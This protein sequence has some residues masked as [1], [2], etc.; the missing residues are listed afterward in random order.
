MSIRML[1]VVLL[2]LMVG[3]K[4][5]YYSDLKQ[6]VMEGCAETDKSLRSD[7]A[8]GLT[9]QQINYSITQSPDMGW[10]EWNDYLESCEELYPGFVRMR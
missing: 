10:D 3:C 7:L 2:V 1:L 4:T 6:K 8:K 9:K 5:G